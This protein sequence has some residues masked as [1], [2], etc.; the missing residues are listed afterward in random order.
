MIIETIIRTPQFSKNGVAGYVTQK[1]RI[2]TVTWEFEPIELIND[3]ST[4]VGIHR[5][6]FKNEEDYIKAKVK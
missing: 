3:G 5:V 4:G 1:G 6:Y 2:S